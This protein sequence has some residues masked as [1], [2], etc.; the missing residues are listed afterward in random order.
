MLRAYTNSVATILAGLALCSPAYSQQASQPDWDYRFRS[1]ALYDDNIDLSEETAGDAWA[2]VNTFGIGN[3]TSTRVS[4]FSMDVSGHVRIQ[5]IPNQSQTLRFDDPRLDLSYSR[6]VGDDSISFSAG[7]REVDIAFLDALESSG[8]LNDDDFDDLRGEGN[9]R[10]LYARLNGIFNE[11]APFT[12]A[13]RLGAAQQRYYDLE[14]QRDLNDRDEFEASAS[15]L[16][17]I[18]RTMRAALEFGYD[19]RDTDDVAQTLRR[20]GTVATGLNVAIDEVTALNLRIGYSE[21]NTERQALNREDTEEGVVGSIGLARELRNGQVSLNYSSNLD[22][23]G[24]R[25]R[26]TV[27]RTYERGT[28]NYG[29]TIGVTASEFTNDVRPIGS[30]FFNHRTPRARFGANLSQNARTDDEGFDAI[31]TRLNLTYEQDIASDLS[32]VLDLG[33][34]RRFREISENRVT[35]R[36]NFT[37]SMR[38]ALNQDWDIDVGYRYRFREANNGD[39]ADSNALFAAIVR[40]LKIGN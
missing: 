35:R 2:L 1:E 26:L 15:F 19:Y 36:L 34:A 33:A 32:F 12:F 11:D 14:D 24:Q 22:E 29:G 16:F 38:K 13:Y 21:V 27:G 10:T 5:D 37:A 6:A 39:E 25:D 9:R 7:A 17:D 20:R 8:G 31:F 18:T 3:R 30:L 4:D 28:T 23:N 40:D